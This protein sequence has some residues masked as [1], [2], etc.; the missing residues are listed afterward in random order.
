MAEGN[1]LVVPDEAGRDIN[2]FEILRV[3]VANKAQHV[4]LRVGVWKDP[5]AWGIMLADLAGHIANAFAQEMHLDRQDALQRIR[6][7]F[8][9]ELDLPTDTPTGSIVP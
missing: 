1:Q 4:S 6:R 3:W 2:S 9:A 7:G 5:F 8:E